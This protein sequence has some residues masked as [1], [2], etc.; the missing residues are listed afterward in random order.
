MAHSPFIFTTVALIML[1][2]TGDQTMDRAPFC[3][4]CCHARGRSARNN[5]GLSLRCRNRQTTYTTGAGKRR[6]T[7]KI[8]ASKPKRISTK[9]G[10]QN[11]SGDGHRHRGQ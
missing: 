5:R 8:A 6:T 9:R 4:R 10:V 2:A 1:S 7:A 3:G 11:W